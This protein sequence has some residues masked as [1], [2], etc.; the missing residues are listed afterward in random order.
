MCHFHISWLIKPISFFLSFIF[1]KSSGAPLAELIDAPWHIFNW[2]GSLLC[3]LWDPLWQQRAWGNIQLF[4][5]GAKELLCGDMHILDAELR[6]KF[7]SIS[8]CWGGAN[9]WL[10]SH[11]ED[12][13][14]GW[15]MKKNHIKLFSLHL[16]PCDLHMHLDCIFNDSLRFHVW[17]WPKNSSLGHL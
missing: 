4:S 15:K 8:D 13:K 14:E 17:K 2:N 16:L 9:L 10:I 12:F 5:W 11:Y 6:E 3:A 1:F 7:I